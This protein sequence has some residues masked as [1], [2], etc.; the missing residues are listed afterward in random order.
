MK[1]SLM[2]AMRPNRS[3]DADTQQLTAHGRLLPEKYDLN[4]HCLS[5]QA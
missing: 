1:A 3:F 4:I 5:A 2:L